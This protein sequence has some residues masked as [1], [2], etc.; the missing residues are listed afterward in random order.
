MRTST[1]PDA[2]EGSAP[3]SS[4]RCTSPPRSHLAHA[5]GLNFSMSN[6]VQIASTTSPR[7]PRRAATAS[8]PL[9]PRAKAAASVAPPSPASR[10]NQPCVSA[11]RRRTALQQASGAE[12][13]PT[14]QRAPF[15]LA[16]RLCSLLLSL[17]L[18]RAHRC[19]SRFSSSSIRIMRSVRLSLS[20]PHPSRHPQADPPLL[21]REQEIRPRLPHPPRARQVRVRLRPVMAAVQPGQ[22]EQQGR[23][24]CGTAGG[25]SR[26][27]RSSRR[28][29]QR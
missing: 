17:S 28:S 13:G 29:T 11:A 9:S 19:A 8:L 23:R 10:S 24:A 5:A 21:R 1:F 4:P 14:A 25:A 27:A 2:D 3:A 18:V 6:S 26:S 12:W 22:W 16:R 7:R 20:P 15:L